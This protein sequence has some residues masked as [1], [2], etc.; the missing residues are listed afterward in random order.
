VLTINPSVH[1][2]RYRAFTKK[3]VM[4]G[5]ENIYWMF[6]AAAQTVAAFIGFILAGYALIYT[7]MEA[8]AQADETLLEIHESLKQRYHRQ[9]SVLVAITA[10][11]IASSLAV[12]YFNAFDSSW[13]IALAWAAT[14]FTSASIAGGVAF[15]ISIVDPKKYHKAAQRM[16][17]EVRPAP[18]TPSAQSA[19]F[20]VRFVALEQIVRDLWERRTGGER[21]A[22]RP[23]PP[24][25]R[26]MVEALLLAE[27]MPRE[28]YDRLLSISR[29]RNLVFHGQVTDINRE[30]LQE[31]A[32]ATKQLTSINNAV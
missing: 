29:Y 30:I 7:I 21:L 3:S 28:L 9:L 19:E 24:S 26:E 23:G 22:R 11:S 10:V 1:P 20:F 14:L 27:V 31:L 13:I 4:R 2:A 15:V 18:E 25:F 6:S 17:D 16:A 8:A 32:L 5:A 12:V